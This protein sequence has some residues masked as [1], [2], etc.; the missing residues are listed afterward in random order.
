MHCII[1]FK[2]V[3]LDIKWY[4][5]GWKETVKIIDL[6]SYFSQKRKQ[7]SCVNFFSNIQKQNDES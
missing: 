1:A 3:R 5:S 7:F 4:V 6:F 2:T